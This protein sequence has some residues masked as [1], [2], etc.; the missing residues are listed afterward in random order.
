[1]CDCAGHACGALSLISDVVMGSCRCPNI[2]YFEFLAASD[3]NRLS[4]TAP[5]KICPNVRMRTAGQNNR[6]ARNLLGMNTDSVERHA[7]VSDLRPPW[8]ADACIRSAS[9]EAPRSLHTAC[10]MR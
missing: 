8:G 1:M 7:H 6:E 4:V 10:R 2:S 9:A 3:I 5:D